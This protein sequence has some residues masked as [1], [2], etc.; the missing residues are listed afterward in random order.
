MDNF[1]ENYSL[2]KLNQEEIAQ[3]NRLIAGNEI[4]Y[5]IKKTP[6]N[7]SPGPDGFTGK[8]Y[9]TFKELTHILLKLSQRLKKECPQRRSM[10]PPLPLY[11]CI[12]VSP[13]LSVFIK[14]I[15]IL[16]QGCFWF[17]CLLSLSSVCAGCYPFDRDCAGV[18]PVC[19]PGDSGKGQG[20]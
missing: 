4:E 16:L 12:S 19:F 3:L 17:G 5:V 8:F 18:W 2:P 1:L 7:K 6:T 20:M 13:S 11:L 15:Y 10:K 14:C 9:Q